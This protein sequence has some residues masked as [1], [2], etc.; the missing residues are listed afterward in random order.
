MDLKPS[1]EASN[2]ISKWLASGCIGWG[3][4]LAEIG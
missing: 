4:A 1:R 2:H 3:G